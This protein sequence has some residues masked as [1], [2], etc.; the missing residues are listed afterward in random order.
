MR[1][2]LPGIFAGNVEKNMTNKEYSVTN[3]TEVKEEKINKI[4]L[5]INQKINAIFSSPNYVYKA[6]VLITTNEGEFIK[7]IIGKSGNN[8]ITME[9]ELINIDNIKDIK[10]NN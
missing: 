10:F 3:N 4:E 5:N 9:N 2:D 1:K 7:R 6:D 8:L